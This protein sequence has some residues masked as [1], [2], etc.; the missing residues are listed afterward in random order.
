MELPNKEFRK[1]V[2]EVRDPKKKK[3][4]YQTQ[5]QRKISWPEY[6]LSKINELKTAL[7][8]I[9]DS[10]NEI[11]YFEQR[12]NVGRPPTSAHVLAKAIL[13]CEMNPTPERQGEGWIE[14]FG[15][16]LGI[17]EKLDDRVIGEAYGRPDVIQILN[18][19]F[20]NKKTSD[21]KL[22]GDGT[23]LERSRKEN[24]ESTKKKRAGQYM[25]SIVDSREIVQAFDLSGTQECKIMHE[26]I[27]RVKGNS[28]RLDAGFNDRKLVKKIANFGITPYVFP[29]CNNNLNGDPFWQGMYLKFYYN[30]LEW[31]KEYHQRSHT[32]SFHSS[33][34]RRFGIIA[35]LR[36][37]C[38]FTQ[39]LA[40]I[41]IHNFRR[42]S[43][44]DK[45]D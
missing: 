16:F 23:G 15:P 10:V 40:R 26:L 28:L 39:V 44:F 31:L 30:T 12:G 25:T 41:I 19:V 18:E 13:F 38:K 27:E 22:G 34:K 5:E 1:L 20:E 3:E 43:Y 6:N 36:F 42:Q 14:L 11:K 45:V 33:F 24:Y 7:I 8:F 17:Y 35:K 9:R 37:T 32:E 21:S 4:I 2:K 29:K